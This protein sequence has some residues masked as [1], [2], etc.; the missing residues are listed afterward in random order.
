MRNQILLPVDDSVRSRE[1]VATVG[2]LLKDQTDCHLELL[3]CTQ[4]ISAVYQEELYH[5]AKAEQLVAQAQEKK[6]NEVLRECRRALLDTG[7]PPERLELKL[8]TDS[9]DPAEDILAEAEQKKIET[10]A[11]GRRG[12][13]KMET[14]LLGSVSSKIAQYARRRAVWIV[15]SGIQW[16]QKVLIALEEAPECRA[17]THYAAEWLAKIPNLHFTLLHLMPPQP[18]TFWDDGHILSAEEQKQRELQREGWRTEW[19]QRVDKYLAEGRD[20]LIHQGVAPD[21]I[22]TQI[23]TVTQGVAQ[24]LLNEIQRQAFQ[25]VVIGKKSFHEP[26]A[27]NLG[28]HANKLLYGAK[29]TILCL[30]DAP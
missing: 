18:P 1:A 20:T 10:I 4:P 13:G 3:H 22:E 11:I 30:V 26:K 27:F 24:D 14:L 28:S 23:S 2:Q 16:T 25:V 5:V 8:K 12:R 15:D 21:H 6:G 19:R 7:F 9:A 29:G 17:L